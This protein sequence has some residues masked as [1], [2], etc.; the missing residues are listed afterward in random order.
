MPVILFKVVVEVCA[1]CKFSLC[2][3]VAF[4]EEADVVE[5]QP[6]KSSR[7]SLDHPCLSSSC[8]SSD[9]GV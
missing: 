7:S 9:L 8:A 2:P 5:T 4:G 6:S 1:A 3:W